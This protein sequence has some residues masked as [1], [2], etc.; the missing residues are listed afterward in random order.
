MTGL[1]RATRVAVLAGVRS[2]AVQGSADRSGGESFVID[3][4]ELCLK[5]RQ[6]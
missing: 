2:R 5:A 1:S 3:K 6:G 4:K